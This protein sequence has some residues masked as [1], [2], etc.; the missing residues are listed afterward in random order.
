DAI[1]ALA[2]LLPDYPQARLLI[3]GGA[4]FT[5][6]TARFDTRR[7]RQELETLAIELGVADRVTFMG[8]RNDIPEVMAALDVVLMPSWSEPFGIV[9]I[10]AMAM[11]KPLVATMYGG[12]ADVIRSGFDGMLIEPRNPQA[13]ADAL[14]SLLADM[15]ALA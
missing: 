1:R 15:S 10:E 9:G 12:P 4:K 13:L 8:E 3:V 14:R 5:D 2:L 11:E 6:P 7:Y